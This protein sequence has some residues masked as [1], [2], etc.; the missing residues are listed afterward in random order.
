MEETNFANRGNL[1]ASKL[2]PFAK[3][4][5]PSISLLKINV[6]LFKLYKYLQL[7]ISVT[8]INTLKQVKVT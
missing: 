6:L 1:I 7:H 5:T 4:V 3:L 2:P 8:H